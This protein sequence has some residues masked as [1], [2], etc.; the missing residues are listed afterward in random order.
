MWEHNLL[1]HEQQIERV[2]MGRHSRL[3]LDDAKLKLNASYGTTGHFAAMMEL[4]TCP[5]PCWI[6][7][8][9]GG[10]WWARM[11]AASQILKARRSLFTSAH[12]TTS[13][14][15]HKIAPFPETC[16]QHHVSEHA[17]Q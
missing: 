11:S 13:C 14:K 6:V 10:W 12:V 4:T 16:Q 17:A 1:L 8:N 9:A 2:L 5:F 7:G 15:Q 3:A